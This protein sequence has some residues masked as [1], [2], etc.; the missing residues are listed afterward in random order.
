MN[1]SRSELRKKEK[2]L[3]QKK[4]KKQKSL[5]DKSLR[6][7]LFKLLKETS[8]DDYIVV[9]QV[10]VED[11]EEL[12]QHI[13]HASKVL[14]LTEDGYVF[15]EVDG[16]GNRMADPILE[17]E[18][19]T[20][21]YQ[22][23]YEEMSEQIIEAHEKK[24]KEECLLSAIR[25]V[26]E[27]YGR[28]LFAHLGIKV[29]KVAEERGALNEEESVEVME[30]YDDDFED[31]VADDGGVPISNTAADLIAARN[32]NKTKVTSQSPTIP[33]EVENSTE[34]D[35]TEAMEESTQPEAPGQTDIVEEED[36]W[37][38]ED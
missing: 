15:Y 19:S 5:F 14:E 11:S 20:P 31:V 36:D 23:W 30:D 4:V 27:E 16:E 6:L 26:D 37:D 9:E 8:L 28:K 7:Q 25:N 10:S 1:K 33:A 38:E 21:A 29:V 2:L 18:V 34:E 35:T 13:F 3:A 24:I 17:L 22:K 12:E 32:A